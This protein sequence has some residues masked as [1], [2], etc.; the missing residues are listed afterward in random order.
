[1]VHG[2]DFVFVG[3]DG[4]LAWVQS[5]MEKRFLVKVIGKLGG[6][7][8]DLSELRVLNRVLCWGPEGIRM[9]ADPATKRSS[10]LS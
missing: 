3:G 10:R 5:E 1:V 4:D 2:D 6:D 9:E 8:G 7:A